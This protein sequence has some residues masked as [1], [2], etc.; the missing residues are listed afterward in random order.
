M[1]EGQENSNE[2]D[3]YVTKDCVNIDQPIQ[4]AEEPM[5]PPSRP[6]LMKNAV[7]TLIISMIMSTASVFVYDQYYATKI[8]TINIPAFVQAQFKLYNEKKITAEQYMENLQ[9]YINHVKQIP[10]NK[11]VLLEDVVAANGK[12]YEEK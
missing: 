12:K 9:G 3:V 5:V 1:S 6:S 2:A 11:V 7:F 4:S 10:K 8:V